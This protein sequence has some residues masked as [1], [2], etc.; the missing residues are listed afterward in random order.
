[1]IFFTADE[2]Y[3]HANIISHCNRPFENIYEMSDV[4]IERHN[5]AVKDG[6]LV[7]HLG[8]MFW[9]TLPLKEAL[10]IRHRLN[11]NHYYILGNHEEMLEKHPVLRDTF[12]W[13]K[14]RERIKPIGGPRSGIVLDHFAGRVWDKQHKGSWQLYGHSHGEL[15]ED[16]SFSLDVGVDA[17]NFY[18]VSID[19]VRDRMIAKGWKEGE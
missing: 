5:S 12:V 1:M 10:N 16:D 15:K 3:G 14:T 13:V 8:D 11:G 2:H 19:D 4:L 7:Y 9:R 18:P 6:D 17:N